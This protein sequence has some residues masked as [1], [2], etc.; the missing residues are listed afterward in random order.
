MTLE[1]K[2]TLSEETI[3]NIQEL[4]K[5]NVD[6]RDTF[7][8]L[9]D[10]TGNASVAIMFRELAS[11]RNRNVAELESLINFNGKQPDESGTVVGAY[12]RILIN[13]RSALGAGTTTMLNEAESAEDNIK[14]RYEDIL[15]RDPASAAGDV[16]HRQYAGI[17]AAHDRVRSIRD[18]HLRAT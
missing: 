12:H 13:L 3:G 2:S 9:A 8:E 10:N 14:S 15:K 1:T 18:A 11:E 6:S 17:R 5:I 4:I 16:L 7:Q